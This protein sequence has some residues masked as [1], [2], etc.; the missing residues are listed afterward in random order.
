[1]I[2]NDSGLAHI[3]ASLNTNLIVLANGTHFGRF[4]PYPPEAKNVKTL[5]P[6]EI[7]DNLAD[8]QKL[9][10]LYKYRSRLN[11]NSIS[12]EKVI[13]EADKMLR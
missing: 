3:A 1:M 11:I 5:Y 2:S 9:R 8:L 10:N 6:P 12:A 4:F 13:F 7:G